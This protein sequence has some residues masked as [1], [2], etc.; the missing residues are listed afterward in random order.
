MELEGVSMRFKL[1]LGTITPEGL[2]S[3]LQNVVAI[4]SIVVTVLRFIQSVTE[5][6]GK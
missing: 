1:Q 2:R 3:A 5:N 4:L 6:R